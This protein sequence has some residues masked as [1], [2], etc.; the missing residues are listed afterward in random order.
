MRAATA[1]RPPVATPLAAGEAIA[2]QWNGSIG[3][4]EVPKAEARACTVR[5]AGD[6][7]V[8]LLFVGDEAATREV[9]VRRLTPKVSGRACR[10]GGCR[11]GLEVHA[12]GSD[13]VFEFETV[14]D[15]D[16]LAASLI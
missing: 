5:V 16:R 15:R 13:I 14:E 6:S 11:P 9:P 2:A 1:K 12:A 10:I 8:A 4:E 3:G 7:E